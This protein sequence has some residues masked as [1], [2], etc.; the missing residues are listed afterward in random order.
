MSRYD[1]IADWYLDFTRDWPSEPVALV[2]YDVDGASVLD[3]ACGY[4]VASRYLARRGAVVTA[5]DLSSKLI[6]RAVEIEAD[7]RLGIRYLHGDVVTR[8]WW[9][10]APFDG[11]LCNMALMDIDD[12]DGALSTVVTVVKPD[13]WFSISL[14]H[15]CFPGGPGDPPAMSSWPPD[16][17]Y[18]AEGRWNTNGIG[19]RGHAGVNHRTLSTY[20]NALVRAGFSF[21]ELAEPESSSIPRYLTICCRAPS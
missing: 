3:L 1:E 6:A 11:V 18:A 13:G 14:L 9:D 21:Q 16:R 17:G 4:G 15:P 12:L 7:E 19:V 8:E 10:G 5:V 20:L 2:P